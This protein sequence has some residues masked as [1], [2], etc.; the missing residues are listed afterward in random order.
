MPSP[1]APT[2]FGVFLGP[3]HKI[4]VD[5]TLLLERDLQPGRS[6]HLVETAVLRR[7]TKA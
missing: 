6:R 5:P 7:K 1:G 2:K 4:G 3:Y